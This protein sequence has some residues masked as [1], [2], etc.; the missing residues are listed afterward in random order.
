MCRLFGVTVAV[1]VIVAPWCHSAGVVLAAAPAATDGQAI[2]GPTTADTLR[3]GA[4][5]TNAILL[6]EVRIEV[7]RWS[8]ETALPL[9]TL[10]PVHTVR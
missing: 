3:A 1:W 8:A 2:A 5:S 9:A 4:D 7:P 10:A 6:P